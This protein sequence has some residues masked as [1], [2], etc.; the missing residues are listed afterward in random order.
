M[1]YVF[2]KHKMIDGTGHR[3]GG[4]GQEDQGTVL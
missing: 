1:A 2:N 3:T 4:T